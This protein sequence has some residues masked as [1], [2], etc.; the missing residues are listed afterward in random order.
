MFEPLKAHGVVGE[1]VSLAIRER[2]ETFLQTMG[3]TPAGEF[4]A[5]ALAN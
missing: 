4:Q 1:E 3:L 5:S 2:H